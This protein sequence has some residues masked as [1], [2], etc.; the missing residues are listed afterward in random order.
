MRRSAWPSGS[1]RAETNASWNDRPPEN[2]SS[3]ASLLPAE[4]LRFLLAA[5]DA[6]VWFAASRAVNEQCTQPP[7]GVVHLSSTFCRRGVEPQID[8]RLRVDARVERQGQEVF[9]GAVS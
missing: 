9:P 2:F 3:P 4:Q 5:T 1:S 7:L 6:S 8:V